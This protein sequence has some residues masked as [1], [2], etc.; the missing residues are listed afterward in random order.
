MVSQEAS[1]LDGEIDSV[2]LGEG[3]ATLMNRES[4]AVAAGPSGVVC[5]AEWNEVLEGPA[6]RLRRDVVRFGWT[7]TLGQRE[8]APKR[9]NELAVTVL[10][11]AR[12]MP[13]NIRIPLRLLRLRARTFPAP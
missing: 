9:S 13:D 11:A 10:W 5:P 8:Q 2:S 12:S 4:K 1:R 7:A 3:L 6:V